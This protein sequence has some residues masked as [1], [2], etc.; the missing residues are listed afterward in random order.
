MYIHTYTHGDQLRGLIDNHNI[1]KDVT[2]NYNTLKE[3]L[4]SQCHFLP[5]TV[6]SLWCCP[7]AQ[8]STREKKTMLDEMC[9]KGQ[10]L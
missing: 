10:I 7:S 6:T 5:R 1:H 8:T 4:K 9:L 2:H 3:T